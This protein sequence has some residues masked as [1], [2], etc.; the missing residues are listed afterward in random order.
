[1]RDPPPPP[2]L[3]GSGQRR[4]RWLMCPACAFK[5]TQPLA[6]CDLGIPYVTYVWASVCTLAVRYAG[7]PVRNNSAITHSHPSHSHRAAHLY[8]IQA[9]AKAHTPSLERTFFHQKGVCL[10]MFSRQHCL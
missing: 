9:V 5:E 7:E 4:L 3:R 10:N 6:I 2:G 1:M 8:S